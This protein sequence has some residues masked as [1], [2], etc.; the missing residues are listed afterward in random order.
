MPKIDLSLSLAY[1]GNGVVV[2]RDFSNPILAA[3]P[4]FGNN[5][6]LEVSQVIFSGG[7][8]KNGIKISELSAQLASLEAEDNRQNI[9]FLLVGHYLEMCKLENQIL[10]FDTHIAQTEKML[11]NMRSQYKEGTAI[12]NDITRYELQ[13][14]NLK[15][16]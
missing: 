9:R 6:A 15:Y 14:Q 10:V 11:E 13:L 16:T 3:I 4:P 5:F 2:D 12:Q 1:N 7:A 8:I